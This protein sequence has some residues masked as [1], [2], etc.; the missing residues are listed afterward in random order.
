MNEDWRSALEAASV[1][2]FYAFS[3]NFSAADVAGTA[4]KDGVRYRKR[5][6]ILLK[7]FATP[8]IGVTAN[9]ITL[10]FP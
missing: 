9:K 8:R 2:A 4:E 5:C 7:H 6:R 3:R 1:A 10:S